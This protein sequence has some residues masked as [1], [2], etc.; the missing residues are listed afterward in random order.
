[1]KEMAMNRL[2]LALAVWIGAASVGSASLTP[3]KETLTWNKE[4]AQTVR[5]AAQAKETVLEE[6]G[7][8]EFVVGQQTEILLDGKPCEY[9]QIPASAAILRMEVAPDRK[10]AVR[11]YFRTRK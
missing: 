1:M 8:S 3:R 2:T 6:P 5:V 4:A 9:R 7:N 10:T 11:I